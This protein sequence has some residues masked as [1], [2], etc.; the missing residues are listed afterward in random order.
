MSEFVNLIWLLL[1]VFVFHDLEEIITVERWLGQ[2]RAQVLHALPGRLQK[3]M[4]PSLAM[5]TAQ[6]AVAVTCIFAVLVAAVVLA[7]ATLPLGTYLPFFLVCLHVMFLHVFTHIGHTIV[8]RAYTPGVVTAVILVLPYS[9]YTYVRLFEAGV[10]T[11]SLV[12]STLPFCLLAVPILY[13]A[14]WLGQAAGGLVS[15]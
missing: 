6:F 12:W 8:L 15:R 1:V 7:A 9:V 10:I 4:E 5:N 2:K 11:W 14:H 13:V 3:L